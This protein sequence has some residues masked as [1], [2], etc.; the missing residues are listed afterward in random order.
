ML[1]GNDANLKPNI[2]NSSLGEACCA[3]F[4]KKK[5]RNQNIFSD[6]FFVKMNSEFEYGNNLFAASKSHLHNTD[7][8]SVHEF[9]ISL[10]VIHEEV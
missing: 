2:T 5:E 7:H 4:F 10:R 9:N 1:I 6:F 3:F 8:G